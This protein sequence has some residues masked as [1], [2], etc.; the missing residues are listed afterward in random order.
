M[1]AAK[2][3]YIIA[4]IVKIVSNI[5]SSPANVETNIAIYDGFYS[6]GCA[7]AQFIVCGVWFCLIW[8]DFRFGVDSCIATKYIYICF[9]RIGIF[10]F[11]AVCCLLVRLC[12]SVYSF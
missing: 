12:V 3:V 5:I 11:K 2:G 9:V 6:V 10:T 4:N 8:I 1:S 7:I